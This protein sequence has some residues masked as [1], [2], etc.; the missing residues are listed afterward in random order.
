MVQLHGK[1]MPWCLN[2]FF[3]HV[4]TFL[5]KTCD[6]ERVLALKRPFPWTTVKLWKDRQ[7]AS[8]VA[9]FDSSVAVAARNHWE[10][11]TH[12]Y[13]I[14]MRS[15]E[16]HLLSQ[17]TICACLR[18]CVCYCLIRNYGRWP[19]FCEDQL[20]MINTGYRPDRYCQN[21]FM[22]WSLKAVYEW[23]SIFEDR[24]TNE[25]SPNI[26]YMFTKSTEAANRGPE[27]IIAFFFV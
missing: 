25:R 8:S 23:F 27:C 18:Y 26:K 17:S 22:M 12:A 13:A 3:R 6:L 2:N 16:Y 11:S 19:C 24:S 4:I 20:H 15:S 7:E 21:V 10:W 5:K 1:N 9:V 14:A